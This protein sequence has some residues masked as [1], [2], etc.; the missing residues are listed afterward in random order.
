MGESGREG[1]GM[2]RPRWGTRWGAGRGEEV[3]EVEEPEA[4]ME[5][6]RG[7]GS[8]DGGNPV[9]RGAQDRRKP[10]GRAGGVAGQRNAVGPGQGHG[11]RRETRRL[12]RASSRLMYPKS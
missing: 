4:G 11:G 6:M 1:L 10:N 5:E 2:G 3:E 8:E 12:G 7:E 9:G